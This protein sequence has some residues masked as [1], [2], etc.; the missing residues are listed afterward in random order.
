MRVLG[1]IVVAAATVLTDCAGN[2]SA[3]N[4]HVGYSGIFPPEPPCPAAIQLIRMISPAPGATSVS[5]TIAVIEV[6]KLFGKQYVVALS[7]Q[8]AQAPS[9]A[10]VLSQIDMPSAAS[11]G[12]GSLLAIP[13]LA[14]HTTYALTL[15]EQSNCPSVQMTSDSTFTTQ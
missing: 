12:M 7:P 13:A 1:A 4:S 5:P 10:P 8:P 11:E 6:S 9:N 15:T 3:A 2:S 14:A